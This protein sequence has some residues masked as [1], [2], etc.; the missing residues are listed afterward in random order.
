MKDQIIGIALG[1]SILA[2]VA[3]LIAYQ[4]HTPVQA[5]ETYEI[6]NTTSRTEA[7]E[8]MDSGKCMVVGI[9]DGGGLS[10]L[11]YHAACW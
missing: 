8:W 1:L 4:H 6:K 10:P 9:T 11:V 5:G 2:G 3:G 7:A